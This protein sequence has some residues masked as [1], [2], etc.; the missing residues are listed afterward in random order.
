MVE[1]KRRR[2]GSVRKGALL[3]GVIALAGCASSDTDEA[4]TIQGESGIVFVK[5]SVEAIGNP[6]DGAPSAPGGD[7]IYKD[8]SSPS[9]S[10]INLT[11]DYTLGEGDVS[12]PEIS[13]DGTRVLFSM[14]T[15][16]SPRWDIYE[17]NLATRELHR[18]IADDATANAGDDVDAAYLPDGRIVFTSNRQVGTRAKLADQ[19]TQPYSYL[20][21]YERER[22]LVLHVMDADGG[23]LHQI[24]FNQSHDRNPTVLTSGEIMFARWDHVGGNNHFPIFFTNPDGTSMFVQYGAFSPGNSFLHPREMPDGRVLTS[25]MPLNGTYEGGALVAVDIRNYSEY[26]QPVSGLETEGVGQKQLTLYQVDFNDRDAVAP[27]GRYTTP[28]PLWDGTNRALV[29]WSPSRPVEETNMLTGE[30]EETEGPPLYGI[31]MFDLDKQ[32]L[33]P[34]AIPGEG[35]V[36]TDPIA[37]ATRPVPNSVPDKPLDAALAEAGVGVLNVK[38]V[39]D[40]DD[41]NLMGDRMLTPTEVI[42]KVDAPAGDDRDE[43]ADLAR[44]KDPAQTTASQRP[45]RFL[46][47]TQAVPTPPGISRESIGESD[48][49]MQKIVGYVPLEPDGSFRIRVPADT[50]IGLS[51]VDSNGMAFQVHTNWIQVRAGE[52]RTCNGCHSPRRGS[53]LNASPI[54]GEHPNTKLLAESG[55][56][57]AETRTRLDPA[58]MSLQADMAYEDVW[59]DAAKAGRAPDPA[60]TI[61]YS[62]LATPAPVNGTINFP[63]HVG[64]IFARDRGA[65]TCTGCHDDPNDD[66]IRSAGLDLR[67]TVSATGRMVSYD[68]LMLGDLQFDPVTGAPLIE[69]MDDGDIEM[70][71][72]DPPISA[73]RSDESS[74]S[75]RFME[76]MLE[77]E[78]AAD[79]PLPRATVDHRGML[80][81]SELRVIAEWIDLGGQYYNDPFEVD[82]DDEYRSLDKVRGVVGLSE[83][84]F[85]SSVHPV[86]M[87]ECAGCHRPSGSATRNHDQHLV[88]TGSAEGDYYVTQSLVSN[89]CMPDDNALLRRPI[90]DETDD[91]WPHPLVDDPAV[92]DDPENPTADDIPV[93]TPTDAAYRTIRN[94]IASGNCT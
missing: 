91:V 12:D 1:G 30:P 41:Q 75:S 66:N 40:T 93:L 38:S 5:R 43:V 50:P 45:G 23:N 64:P 21:E 32:T 74:R 16:D 29:A 83:D 92:A 56:S 10:E 61:D 81:A 46:R 86:L 48:M 24:S 20:D 35:F 89:V 26:D 85:E 18:L 87:A 65:A 25:L 51:V 6:T 62:G 57:M 60:L 49:E 90:A 22:T 88:L 72:D 70:V 13:Y 33:R 68:S 17:M 14:R 73:G 94:W 82:S 84:L 9:A 42:P 53:A 63:D 47:V 79:A 8:L 7:L 69:V 37:V 36:Y 11:E 3:A 4:I 19:N 34:V 2:G 78:L 52:T 39:Y 55:E 77:R 28:Y 31:Y 15:P 59:T 71:R 67:A 54:A 58:L 27:Y 76:K 44:M 80:N